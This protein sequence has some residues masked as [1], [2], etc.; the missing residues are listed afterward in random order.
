MVVGPTAVRSEHARRVG[1]VQPQQPG[2]RFE[3]LRILRD[4]SD[5]AGDGKDAIAD[6]DRLLPGLQVG[7]QLVRQILGIAMGKRDDRHAESR[8]EV[9]QR[10][11]SHTVLKDDVEGLLLP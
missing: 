11:V 10:V 2:V 3:D 4:R 1:I 5:L 7:L 9:D 6:H 8:R